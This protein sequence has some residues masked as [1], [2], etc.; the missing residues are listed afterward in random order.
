MV[1]IPLLNHWI[2]LVIVVR[3]I[4]LFLLVNGIEHCPWL[5]DWYLVKT[6]IDAVLSIVPVPISCVIRINIV[7]IMMTTLLPDYIL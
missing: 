7:W 4:N 2:V 5:I 3:A 1:L 6:T